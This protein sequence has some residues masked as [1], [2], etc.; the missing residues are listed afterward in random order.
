MIYGLFTG[1]RFYTFYARS[2]RIKRTTMGKI[3]RKK[4]GRSV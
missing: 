2:K 3:E 4:V 1:D